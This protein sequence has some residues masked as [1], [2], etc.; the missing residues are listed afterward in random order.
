MEYYIENLNDCYKFYA[1][2]IFF[3]FIVTWEREKSKLNNR[4]DHEVRGPEKEDLE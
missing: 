1:N 2:K 3:C 4:Y